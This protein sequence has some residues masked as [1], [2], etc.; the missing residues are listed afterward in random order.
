MT[1]VSGTDRDEARENVMHE[2]PLVPEDVEEAGGGDPRH[3]DHPTYRGDE[4]A[5]G[6]EAKPPAGST[7]L[8]TP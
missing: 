8:D 6:D 5:T 1:E 3:T 2:P 7:G 4:G